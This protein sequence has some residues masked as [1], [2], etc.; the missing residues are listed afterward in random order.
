MAPMSG[1]PAGW[2]DGWMHGRLDEMAGGLA[3]WLADWLATPRRRP[4]PS[5]DAIVQ[6]DGRA[7]SNRHGEDTS[8]R[9]RKL[10]TIT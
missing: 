7:G 3:V 6:N 5:F 4:R 8:K 10:A 2:T 9:S 1:R